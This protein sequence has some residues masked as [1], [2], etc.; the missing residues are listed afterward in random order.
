MKLHENKTLF[1]QAVRFTAQELGILDI[2]VE[3]D[4][5]VTFALKI[6]FSSEVAEYTI[7][8]GGTALS[9]CYGIIERFSEDI[10]L[11]VVKSSEDSGNQL[12]I[13]TKKISQVL[14]P[15]FPEI[16]IEGITQ[17]MG[18]NRKT[19]HSY[20]KE[21]TGEYGQVRDTI[22]VEA[23]W[24]GYFEPNEEK[25]IKTLIAE[26]M[27]KTNQTQ[28]ISEYGLEPFKVSVLMPTRTLCEKIMSIV[29]FSYSEDAISD[30]KSKVRHIYDIHQLLNLPEILDFFNSKKFDEMLLKVAQD[31]IVSYKSNNEWLKNHPKNALVF[32]DR[33]KV[34]K[35][36]EPVYN[37]DFGKL[38]YGE[39]PDSEKMLETLEKV[40]DRLQNIVWDL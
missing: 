38:V 37:Q 13:K 29:R 33:I 19:A 1:N 6:I 26:M 25:E 3:K 9:K 18:M 4:Y 31:D 11:V 14:N 7:F 28:L 17:K 23:S 16:E 2:Y 24:L 40:N 35:E 5:W 15:Y 20:A 8:K 32:A 10:D 27:L 30:L 22:I 39:L 36:I 12:K 34:W 21:F